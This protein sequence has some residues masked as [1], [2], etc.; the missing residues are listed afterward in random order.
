[1][2]GFCLNLIIISTSRQVEN[3]IIKLDKVPCSFIGWVWFS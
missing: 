2:F 3:M 1:L